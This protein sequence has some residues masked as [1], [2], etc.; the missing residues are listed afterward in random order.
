VRPTLVVQLAGLVD[1]L[2]TH[3]R[4][5]GNG[6]VPAALGGTPEQLPQRY[7]AA[8]P[9]E[10]VPIGVPQLVVIGRSDSPDLREMSR[11]YVRAAA[12]G[13]DEVELIED[14][15]D[16]FTVIDPGSRIWQRTVEAATAVL[17]R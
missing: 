17:D 14:D 4:D 11:R 2:E 5:L 16:H 1:L 12:A 13:G 9:I 15:G 10:R 7:A 6:A 8:S 3:R